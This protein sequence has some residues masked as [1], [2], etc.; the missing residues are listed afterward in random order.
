MA[1]PDLKCVQGR[2]GELQNGHGGGNL[3]PR[4]R[5]R[6][7]RARMQDAHY[8]GP[9]TDEPKGPPRP[10]AVVVGGGTAHR[11][12]HIVSHICLCTVYYRLC[13]RLPRAISLVR[14]PWCTRP[15]LCGAR[16]CVRLL[17]R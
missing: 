3:T 17:E 5:L 16:F 15:M 9:E 1:F 2:V 10:A 8:N 12:Y 11:P 14:T 13:P 6:L 7:E 4:T